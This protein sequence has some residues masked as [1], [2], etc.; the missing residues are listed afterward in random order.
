MLA[1]SNLFRSL[2]AAAVLS[3]AVLCATGVAAFAGLL[4]ASDHV[5]TAVTATP[6]VDIQV[7]AAASAE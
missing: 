5:A 3:I 2:I 6:F 7:A 4:P 1:S